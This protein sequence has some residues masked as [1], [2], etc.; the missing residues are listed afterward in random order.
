MKRNFLGIDIGG[1]WLKGIL[2]SCDDTCSAQQLAASCRYKKSVRVNSHLEVGSTVSDFIHSLSILL[3]DLKIEPGKLSGIGVS[4]AGIVRYDGSG[5]QLCA[6]HLSVLM[7]PEWII[8]LKEETGASVVLV[9]DAEA[10]CI[11]AAGLNYLS[12]NV[13]Y[14]IAPIGTGLGFVVLRNGRRWCDSS[15][16][17]PLLGSVYAQTVFN[18]DNL[19]GVSKFA[20]LGSSN[21]LKEFITEAQYEDLRSC[22]LDHLAGVIYSSS[23]LYGVEE[24]CIAGGFANAVSSWGWDVKT[25]LEKRLLR[26]VFYNQKSLHIRV[27]EEGNQ[28]PLIGAVLLARG[29]YFAIQGSKP[30]VYSEVQTEK[31]YDS[32]IMLH[33]LNTMSILEKLFMLEQEAGARL[34]ESLPVL[35]SVID[36]IIPKLA[37]GGRLIYVGCGTSGRLAAI[38]AVELACTFGFPR[39]KVLT[40]IS[41]GVTDAAIDIEQNFEEDASA[42]P[43]LLMAN[44]SSKDVVIG[45][46]VSGRAFYVQ[47]ALAYAKRERALSVMVQAVDVKKMPFC[48][49]VLPLNTGGELIAGSTRMK[50]GTATKKIL[51]FISTTVM[52]RLGK[53]HGC[54]MT[55][56][57]CLNEKLVERAVGILQSLFGLS[58]V[59]AADELKLYGYNLNQTI[60]QLLINGYGKKVSEL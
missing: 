41:G 55:E 45:I 14:G 53:V 5:M 30:L 31:P 57:E 43:E 25:E 3:Q 21:S 48:D 15:V 29:N 12:G 18:F 38:D 7:S 22:Y 36:R 17:L 24:F 8:Y 42:V 44:I 26:Y 49:Y 58:K 20:Q 51:N 35:S 9:N 19:V 16:Q 39:D 11:G 6:S 2:V 4:S 33:Q 47:S 13:C 46:S 50:A 40:F 23:V 27:F 10:A 60:K 56:L 54:Y 28:L 32:S 52:I 59:E 34:K 37:D 1:T